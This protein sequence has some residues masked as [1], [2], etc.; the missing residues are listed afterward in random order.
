M[1]QRRPEWPQ[2]RV[3]RRWGNRYLFIFYSSFIIANL[4]FTCLLGLK[5][6]I[7]PRTDGRIG[8]NDQNGPNDELAVVGAIG[9]FIFIRLLLWLTYI[10]LAF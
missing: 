7:L 2:R 9:T 8:S 6:Q 10:L 4:Y 1:G 5:S 3:S